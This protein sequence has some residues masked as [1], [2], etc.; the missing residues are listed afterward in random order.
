M[1]P[2]ITEDDE[3]TE[4]RQLQDK[5]ISIITKKGFQDDDVVI[6]GTDRKSRVTLHDLKV[7]IY[8]DYKTI[9]E[10]FLED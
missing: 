7:C 1:K 2:I 5:V 9:F 10:E 4:L 8:P 3:R 6:D